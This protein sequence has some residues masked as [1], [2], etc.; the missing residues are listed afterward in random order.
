MMLMVIVVLIF[1][2]IICWSEIPKM[3]KE[4]RVKDISVFVSLLGGALTLGLIKIMKVS[5]P[6]PLYI[7]IWLCKP[8]S[9]L[10]RMLQ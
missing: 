6:T 5:V 2:A 4:R 9:D 7:V 10:I 1:T 8:L 3:W